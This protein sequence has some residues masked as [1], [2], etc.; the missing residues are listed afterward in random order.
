[1]AALPYTVPPAVAFAFPLRERCLDQLVEGGEHGVVVPVVLVEEGGGHDALS[2]CCATSSAWASVCGWTPTSGSTLL[3]PDGGAVFKVLLGV[4]GDGDMWAGAALAKLPP[5][6]YSLPSDLTAERA[7]RLALGFALGC[8]SFRRYK[9]TSDLAPAKPLLCWP[10]SADRKSVA[11]LA[12]AFTLARDL[13]STPAEDMGP[14]HMC[15]EAAALAAAHAGASLTVLTGQQLLDFNYPAVHT[16]GRASSRPPA[17]IDLTWC[18]PGSADGG[19]GLP[20]V[21]LVGKG[22]CFDSGGLNLKPAATMLTMKKD[23]GGAALLMGLA[24]VVMTAKL[25]VRLRLMVPAIDNSVSSDAFRPLDVLQTRSGITVENMHTDAEGR[26][27]LCDA[28]FECAQQVPDLL[29]DAATLTGAARMALGPEVPAVF[30]NDDATW[31]ALEAAAQQEDDPLWRLPLH[32]GYRRRLDSKVADLSSKGPEAAGGAIV[33][34]LYL[35]E[36]VKGA[37]RWLHIDT[38]AWNASSCDGRPEGGEALGLRAL[39]AFLKQ[40]Y[41]PAS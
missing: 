2:A 15:A 5:G 34:A 33:A 21:C 19:A 16:V 31:S 6:V 12:E 24:H 11:V 4:D 29:L 35:Q 38:G 17:L 7:H 32:K 26:L 14:Q 36:F 18:P 10:A 23:M 22:V 25:P 1:M 28:L 37:P 20:L 41:T 9:A 8:F 3:V 30:S 27:I 39:W 13:I 40:R